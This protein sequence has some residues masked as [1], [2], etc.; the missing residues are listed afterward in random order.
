MRSP[1]KACKF[2]VSRKIF[3]NK[4]VRFV[5][6][7]GQERR[8]TF[9]SHFGSS[10]SLVK[11]TKALK[12]FPDQH[13][14]HGC[15]GGLIA[16]LGYGRLQAAATVIGGVEPPNHV[17]GDTP[18]RQTVCARPRTQ[19]YPAA[20]LSSRFDLSPID[21]LI[22]I[23]VRCGLRHQTQAGA[24]STPAGPGLIAAA[25][26][27]ACETTSRYCLQRVS[28]KF[29]GLRYL[30]TRNRDGHHNCELAN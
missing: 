9:S 20:S 23:K 10:S 6:T 1:C 21:S 26:Q 25:S 29:G 15:P 28:L 18:T 7:G 14:G 3:S 5:G 30:P 22:G 12:Y 24:I 17:I 27:T 2:A 4:V 19:T 8:P 13:F 16:E 11:K